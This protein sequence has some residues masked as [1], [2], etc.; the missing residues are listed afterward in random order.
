MPCERDIV[1]FEGKRRVVVA[2]RIPIF[3]DADG[4]S[5]STIERQDVDSNHADRPLRA[6]LLHDLP[7]LCVSCNTTLCF[8]G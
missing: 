2:H 1:H 6:M 5:N 8:D 7:G 4:P 3:L